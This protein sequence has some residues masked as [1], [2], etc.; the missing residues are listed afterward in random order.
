MTNLLLKV[1]FEGRTKDCHV[2]G[3]TR[4]QMSLQA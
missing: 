1:S 2:H 3:S 4:V